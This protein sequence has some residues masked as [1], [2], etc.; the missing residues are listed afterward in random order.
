MCGRVQGSKT[1]GKD[2]P[3]TCSSQDSGT[4]EWRCLRTSAG[5]WGRGLGLGLGT[6]GWGLALRPGAWGRR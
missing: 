5:A 2:A 4:T 3:Q 1:K 6:W